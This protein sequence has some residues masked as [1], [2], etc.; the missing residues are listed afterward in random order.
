[1]GNPM[2]ASKSHLKVESHRLSLIPPATS[3]D[4]ML[5]VLST[6]ELIIAQATTGGAGHM[7]SICLAQTKIPDPRHSTLTT[8]FLQ[9]GKSQPIL[10]GNGGNPSKNKA[11]EG[12]LRTTPQTFFI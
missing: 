6:K 5:E 11:P 8:L 12:Q 9:L 3:H 1:M 10:S 2:Q 4:S 7:G